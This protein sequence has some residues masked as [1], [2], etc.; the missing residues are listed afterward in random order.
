MRCVS[1]FLRSGVDGQAA[2]EQRFHGSS[3]AF[4]QAG[5]KLDVGAA[6]SALPFG[7]GLVGDA[8]CVGE[9]AAG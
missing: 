4:G 6:A 1:W 2:V 5:Q 8:E 3:Q 7:H 9:L